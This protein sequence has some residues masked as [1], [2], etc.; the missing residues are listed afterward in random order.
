LIGTGIGSKTGKVALAAV[1]GVAEKADVQVVKDAVTAVEQMTKAAAEPDVSKST[2]EAAAGDL[3][4]SAVTRSTTNAVADQQNVPQAQKR[5]VEAL[6]GTFRADLD[7]AKANPGRL[8]QDIVNRIEDDSN[9]ATTN[10]FDAVQ[11]I[12]KNERLPDVLANETAV[13]AI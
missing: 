6:S 11:T 5:A 9:R 8:G 3:N 7:A 12:Q 2:I 10:L 13:R 1:K 4:E